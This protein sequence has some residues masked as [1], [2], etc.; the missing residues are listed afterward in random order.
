MG[1]NS[2]VCCGAP[3]SGLVICDGCAAA[4]AREVE[5]QAQAWDEGRWAGLAPF[6]LGGEG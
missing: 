1:D 4:W 6:D 5:R 2:C 3:T